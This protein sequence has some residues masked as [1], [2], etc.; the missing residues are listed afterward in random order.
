MS[1]AQSPCSQVWPGCKDNRVT[2]PE[3]GAQRTVSV[4]QKYQAMAKFPLLPQPI[5][6]RQTLCG[7]FTN[8]LIVLK[9]KKLR[10]AEHRAGNLTTVILKIGCRNRSDVLCYLLYTQWGLWGLLDQYLH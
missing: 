8:E 2:G 3:P 1:L 7:T 5:K 10:G 9:V 6:S 4:P